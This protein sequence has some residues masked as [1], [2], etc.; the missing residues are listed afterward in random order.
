MWRIYVLFWNGTGFRGDLITLEILEG[1]AAG[2]IDE[3]NEKIDQLKEKGFRISMDDFGS[4]YSSFNILGKLHIDELKMDRVF[5]SAI[6]GK[7]DERQK[8]IMAQV[9][10]LAKK[11]RIS[12]VAEGVE[13]K[14]MKH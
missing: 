3:L 9:V 7:E 6:T 10:D 5:L 1:L 12:T 14:E 2:N 13:T 11:L 4:G 8:I